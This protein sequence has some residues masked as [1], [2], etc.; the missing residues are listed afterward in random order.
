MRKSGLTLIAA[1]AVVLTGGA[2]AGDQTLQSDNATVREV[3]QSLLTFLTFSAIPDSTADSLQIDSNTGDDPRVRLA[4]IGGGFTVSE[5]TPVYLEG[6]LGY[7]SYDPDFVVSGVEQ[8]GVIAAKWRTF[9]ATGGVGYDFRIADDWVLRPIA[10]LS[11]SHMTSDAALVGTIFE[12]DLSALGLDARAWLDDGWL[13][14]AGL[15]GSLVLDF[16]RRRPEYEADIELRYRRFHLTTIDSSAGAVDGSVTSDTVGLW[17]RL[18]IPTGYQ[19]F[20]R[21]LRYVFEGA[22][23][24]FASNQ[25]DVL[26]FDHLTKVGAGLE[27]DV[28]DTWIPV[29]RVRI[30]GRYVFGEDLSGVS[31]GFGISL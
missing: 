2:A 22:H 26:G 7:A 18:R 10:N 3:T 12:P 6:Y 17:G 1:A 31:I 23:S 20:N 16:E 9:S 4:Q 14:A 24:W 21:P 8:S 29:S 5:T 13:T 28:S 15:G 19:V 25:T 30:L 11:L 27:F